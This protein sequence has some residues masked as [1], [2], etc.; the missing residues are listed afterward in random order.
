VIPLSSILSNFLN[1]LVGF[2]V[3]FLIFL[4]FLWKVILLL[5]MLFLQLLLFLLFLWGLGLIFST[6]NV[7]YR[8]VFYFLSIGL[9]I[10]FWI[11]PIFY[12]LDMIPY[13]Y[14]IV[15]LVNPLTYF[16]L[17]FRDILYY[18]RIHIFNISMSF[19]FSI[20]FFS[21]GYYVFLI[22]EKELLKRL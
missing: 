12:S 17:S 20:F 13:P 1:F 2:G 18:G 21:L 19:A 3:I 8:D 9:M 5:P 10:W 11:T 16:M 6:L 15:C 4:V 22:K 7:F 14:K